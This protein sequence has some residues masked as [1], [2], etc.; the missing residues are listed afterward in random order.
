MPDSKLKALE[1]GYKVFIG[2]KNISGI[3]IDKA[4]IRINADKW[5][6]EDETSKLEIKT[7]LFYKEY[8]IAT[9]ETKLKIEAQLHSQTEGWLGD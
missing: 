1:S 7:G 8:Q 3:D 6:L 4:R 9:N 5:N 2:V